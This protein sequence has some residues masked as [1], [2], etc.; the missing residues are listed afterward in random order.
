[1]TFRNGLIS[2][3]KF[4]IV[5]KIFTF[6]E[7]WK[8]NMSWRT[9]FDDMV[10]SNEGSLVQTIF[11]PVWIEVS[12][13]INDFWNYLHALSLN[14]NRLQSAPLEQKSFNDKH[15]RYV[16][17]AIKESIYPGFITLNGLLLNSFLEIDFYWY[18]HTKNKRLYLFCIKR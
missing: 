7:M 5:G 2:M 18:I 6:T 10:I 17:S 13:M 15:L 16:L 4:F 12:R 8:V 14:Y 11:C 3:I 1:M 9:H